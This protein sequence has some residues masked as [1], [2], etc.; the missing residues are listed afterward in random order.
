M[1]RIEDPFRANTDTFNLVS[2]EK[3]ERFFECMKSKGLSKARKVLFDLPA[4]Q[5][6]E[7]SD[8]ESYESVTFGPKSFYRF[9]VYAIEGGDVPVNDS[10][11]NWTDS[12]QE[13]ESKNG[14]EDSEPEIWFKELISHYIDQKDLQLSINGPK[15]IVMRYFNYRKEQT[16]KIYGV[17]SSLDSARKV[18]CLLAIRAYGA[19][20]GKPNDSHDSWLDI[21]NLIDQYCPWSPKEG[22]Q[23]Y[24]KII[25][26]V[27]LF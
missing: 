23:S 11:V 22:T 8:D 4:S 24:D 13:D 17:Y 7:S 21:D 5:E 3:F 15:Y 25:Y 20:I 10:P 16:L 9:D 12:D 2:K 6:A 14:N 19:F 26:S 27:S 1:P 18:A